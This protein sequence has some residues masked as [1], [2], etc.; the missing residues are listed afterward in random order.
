MPVMKKTRRAIGVT[1]FP[2]MMF[3]LS[4]GLIRALAIL[5]PSMSDTILPLSGRAG[6]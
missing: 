6:A 3:S 1:Q 2:Q 5:V 4:F